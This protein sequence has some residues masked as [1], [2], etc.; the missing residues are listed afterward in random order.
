MKQLTFRIGVLLSGMLLISMPALAEINSI[1]TDLR[2]KSCKLIK[3][4]EFGSSFSRCA[5][6]SG[7]QLLAIA[8]DI[9]ESITVVDPNNKQHPLNFWNVITYAPSHLGDKAEWRVKQKDGKVVPQALIV[10]VNST[11]YDEITGRNDKRQIYLA[12]IKITPQKICVVDRVAGGLDDNQKARIIA[13]TASQMPCLT[14]LP[15]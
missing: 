11:P 4:D 14:K 7:Y 1:Y 2:E 10:R 8:G 6:I 12:V 3:L 5:G 9:R 13:D 15:K